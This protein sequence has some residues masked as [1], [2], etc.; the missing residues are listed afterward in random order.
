MV[1]FCE[2]WPLLENIAGNAFLFDL[3]LFRCYIWHT[4]IFLVVSTLRP[5]ILLFSRS[6]EKVIISELTCPYEE[7]MSHDM[8]KSQRNTI[9]Y[10]A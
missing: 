8:K 10:V 5:D 9:P 3:V 7:N 1:W 2:K 4:A 6:T